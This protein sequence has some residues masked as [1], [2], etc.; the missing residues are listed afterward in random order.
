MRKR[1]GW[2]VPALII[3]VA[4]GVLCMLNLPWRSNTHR[5]SKEP[6][7]NPLMGYA[8]MADGTD[9][10]ADVSLLYMD[11]TWRE[12]EPEKGLYAWEAV[13][14]ENKLG[15][16]RRLGKHIVLRFVMDMPGDE[17]HMD[18]PDWLYEEMD[19]A[20]SW[21]DMEYGKG[22][23]PDYGNEILL[24]HHE[25]A[26]AAL[27]AQFGA[28][29]FISYIELGSLGHWGEW[30]VNYRAG[31]ERLPSEMVRRQY[32][33]PWIEAFPKAMI[34]MRRPFLAASELGLG[35]YNDMAGEPEATGEWLEWI[36][37]GGAYEQTKEPS[38]LAAMPD[39]WKTA[40]S[41]GE[42]TSSLSM[43]DMLTEN[44]EQT[45]KLLK[46][47]HTTFLGPKTAEE[48]CQTGYGQVLKCMGYR[49]WTSKAALTYQNREDCL[50][51][52]WENTGVAPF[53]QDWEV[54]LYLLSK[55]EEVLD[56]YPVDIRLSQLMPGQSVKTG[57][58]VTAEG[59]RGWRQKGWK[60][61][62]GILD[63]MTGEPAVKMAMK[64]Q[65]GTCR[66]VIL[67]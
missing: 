6:L 27:G 3:C 36:A 47:S 30:H 19:G 55:E 64:G 25:R 9:M 62:V 4:A 43:E 23:S 57:T 22:F 39:F 37:K 17:S 51:I 66:P 58:V 49:L 33:T 54:R 40:P 15:Q 34:L 31:I 12:L 61:A 38:G 21:Y 42:F 14:E 16:W 67:K 48:G 63:P 24:A 1:K 59:I 5:E 26:V 46:D 41:G 50:T 13:E 10:D 7:V 8:P 2:I 60:F 28:D 29:G 65:E 53:Y 52:T 18:I 35:L 56:E 20:G 45:I 11:I 44:L 32:I